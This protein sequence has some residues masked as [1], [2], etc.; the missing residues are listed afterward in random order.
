MQKLIVFIIIYLYPSLGMCVF[1]WENPNE[2]FCLLSS[3]PLDSVVFT[4]I[5]E[6]GESYLPIF[7]LPSPPPPHPSS[8]F[9]DGHMSFLPTYKLPG[10]GSSKGVLSSPA[11]LEQDFA[12]Q[13]QKREVRDSLY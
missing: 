12:S 4:S 10:A 7:C 1:A 9:T 13:R 3:H 5:C 11:Y 2:L 8:Q 6:T